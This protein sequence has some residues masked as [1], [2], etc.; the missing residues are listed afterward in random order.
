MHKKQFKKLVFALIFILLLSSCEFLPIDTPDDI[1]DELPIDEIDST[2]PVITLIG[3]TSLTLEVH[4]TYTDLGA[5]CIDDIDASCQVI[6]DDSNLDMS[7]LGTYEIYYDAT[8][9]SQNSAD[10]VIRTITVQDSTNPVITLLGQDS[11]YINLSDAYIDLGATCID[12]Y[13]E[14][15]D[16]VVNSSTVDTTQEG[17]YQVTYTATDDSF[18]STILTRTIHIEDHNNRILPIPSDDI[19]YH[20]VNEPF[21]YP[22]FYVPNEGTY[23]AIRYDSVDPTTLG[24]YEMVYEITDELDHTY[25]LVYHVHVVNELPSLKDVVVLENLYTTYPTI[26]SQLIIYDINHDLI[27]DSNEIT[28]VRSLDLSNLNLNDVDFIKNYTSL[29]S[30]DLSHNDL[31]DI[32]FMSSLVNLQHLNLDTNNLDFNDM[33]ILSNNTV[34]I[35]LNLANNFI[36]DLSSLDGLTHLEDLNLNHNIIYDL[37]TLGTLDSLLHLDVSNNPTDDFNTILTFENLE[38][39]NIDQTEMYDISGIEAIEFLQVL[40]LN[41]NI[42][43]YYYTDYLLYLS[44]LNIPA[45]DADLELS[46]FFSYLESFDIQV[47]INS[48][49]SFDMINPNIILYD[50]SATTSL[51]QSFDFTSLDYYI[52]DADDQYVENGLTSSIPDTSTLT[53]GDHLITLSYTDSDNHTS[54]VDFTLSVIDSYDLGNLVV[55]IR[56]ADETDFVAPHN[57]SYYDD[58]FNGHTSSLR[59]YYLEVSN[60]TFEIDTIFPST[61][62]IYYTDEHVRAYYQP[63][64]MLTNPIGYTDENESSLREYALLSNAIYWLDDAELIDDSVILDYNF[65]GQVDVVTFLISGQVDEWSNLI[66]PHQYAFYD[67]LSSYDE[68]YT[69]APS[70]NGDY[71]F[72]YTFQL[73]GDEIEESTYFNLGVFAHEMFHVISATDLYHYYSDDGFSSVGN[74]DIMD[75]TSSIPSHM[76]LYMK[77]YYGGWAQDEFEVSVDGTYNLNVSTSLEN[78]LIIIDLGYSNEYL[79]IEYRKQTGTYEV[80]I[81][82][83]GVIIYRVDK[84]YEGEG[85]VDGYYSL[86]DAG[87]DEVF[88][89]RP[90]S[91]DVGLHNSQDIYYI[92]DDGDADLGMLQLGSNEAAGPHTNIPLFYSDG[93]E[94]NISITILSESLDEVQILI[95]F[96]D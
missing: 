71:V 29:T 12:N 92:V 42:E 79:Y 58:L 60:N 63:Y 44:E 91:Y 34:L 38:S 17:I 90:L 15:C 69:T 26:F 2:S 13:D 70:I 74:W 85:N 52:Y 45:L 3:D 80:N 43:D 6:I 28:Q 96:L 24:T 84:D 61:D 21:D 36:Q 7:T 18:N 25:L 62:L 73:I 14:T 11:I 64:H 19:I 89:F 93:T 47:N 50:T 10:R 82:D 83:D 32:D 65:D 39:L 49:T 54:S 8:D 4:T 48:S 22:L 57:F 72:D 27:L 46:F 94:I 86:S 30:L 78:N 76:L 40:T 31:Y 33:S 56:F 88:V 16:I 37:T 59:D 75:H 9:T 67:S 41:E 5:T 87:L 81:P 20:I 1:D 53:V 55:F 66:W 68:F 23:S 51:G 77:S 35:S 95:D